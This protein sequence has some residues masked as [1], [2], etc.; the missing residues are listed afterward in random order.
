VPL[1]VPAHAPSPVPILV[2]GPTGYLGRSLCDSLTSRGHTVRALV[3]PGSEGRAPRGAAVVIGNALSAESIGSAMR[4]GD[5]L[6]HLIGTPH[7]GPAKASEFRS[8]DLVS[9]Q[10][11]T[12]AAAAVGVAH[13]IYLSVAHPAPVM[14][15]YVDVRVE[16]ESLV[17]ST[18]IAATLLRPWYVLGPGHRWPVALIPFYWIAERVPAWRTSAQRLGLVTL[19]QMTAALVHAVENPPRAGEVRTVEV[20]EIRAAKP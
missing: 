14:R 19:S 9:I 16:G 11:A 5:T 17:R 4:S 6:V 2:T 13:F 12:A 10:A 7:P 15:A 1:P 8:I 18:G 20:P 3:R